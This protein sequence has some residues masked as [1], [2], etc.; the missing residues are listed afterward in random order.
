MI[1][2]FI[3]MGGGIDGA[4]I[5]TPRTKRQ[6]RGCKMENDC[7]ILQMQATMQRRGQ[8]FQLR[9]SAKYLHRRDLRDQLKKQDKSFQVCGLY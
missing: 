5:V 6:V 3:V 1:R 8:G 4:I 9:G 7:E 2:L